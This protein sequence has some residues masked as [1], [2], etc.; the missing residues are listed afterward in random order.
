MQVPLH[1]QCRLY[2]NNRVPLQKIPH[3][4]TTTGERNGRPRRYHGR[5]RYLAMRALVLI[6]G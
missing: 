4:Q 5:P 6:H 1:S 2:L 3:A